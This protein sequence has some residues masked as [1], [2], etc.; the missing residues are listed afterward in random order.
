MKKLICIWVLLVT[1]AL[2]AQEKKDSVIRITL[3]DAVNYATENSY[4]VRSAKFDL[5][6]AKKKIWETIAIGLPQF[7]A[8]V[9]YQNIFKVPELSFPATTYNGVALS[10]DNQEITI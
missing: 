10:Q 1:F 5:E 4:N 8:T 2:G 6:A 7:S 3:K 9:Q